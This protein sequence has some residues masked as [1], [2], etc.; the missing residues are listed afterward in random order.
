M[1]KDEKHHCRV[2]GLDTDPLL[3]AMML[4]LRLMIFVHVVE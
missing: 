2:C 4:Q 3:G 1:H